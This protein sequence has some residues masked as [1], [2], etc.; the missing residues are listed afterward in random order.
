MCRVSP[1]F[2]PVAA[3]GSSD[4]VAL[5]LAQAEVPGVI[6]YRLSALS[7]ARIMRQTSLR[8]FS[9]INILANR[10]VMPERM[11]DRAEPD[12]L[13]EAVGVLL[14][15]PAQRATQIEEQKQALARLAL[16]AGQSP[17]KLA[18]DTLLTLIRAHRHDLR[19]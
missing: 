12:G 15:D 17:A 13:A 8:H 7:Y 10:E 1:G 14:N 18:A 11:Q 16:P 6:T 2:R 9:L 5:E 19:L 3:V 4:H